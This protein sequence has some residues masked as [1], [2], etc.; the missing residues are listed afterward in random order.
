MAPNRGGGAAP[1]LPH[2]PHPL[3][4]HDPDPP[5]WAVVQAEDVVRRVTESDFGGVLRWRRKPTSPPVLSISDRYIVGTLD[6]RAVDFPCLL[7]FTRCRFERRPDI[8][9]A[10]LCGCQIRNCWLPGLF[11]RNLHSD[12]DVVLTGST[13]T[14]TVDLTDANVNGSLDLAGSTLVNPKGRALHADR[15]VLAGALIGPGITVRGVLRLAGVRTGGNINLAGADLQNETG[16]AFNGNGMHVGG[17]LICGSSD[18]SRDPFRCTGLIFM[19]SARID[20]DFYLRRAKLQPSTYRS[21][22]APFEDPQHDPIAVVVA[23]RIAVDGNVVLDR[24]MT[25]TGTIRMINARIGGSMR[26]TGATVDMSSYA[27][28]NKAPYPYRALHFDGT[29]I[30]GDIDARRARITGESR[31]VDVSVR[32]SVLADD[33]TF[34]NPDGDALEGRRLTVGGNFDCRDVHIAGSFLLPGATIGANLDMRATEITSPGTRRGGGVK[35]S[36]DIRAAQIGRDL[37]CASG[38]S[39]F[40]AHA[41]V[42]MHRATVG[43]EANFDGAVLGCSVSSA[44]LNAFGMSTQDLRLTVGE[45]PCGEVSLRHARCTTLSDNEQFWH[46]TGRIDLED[47]HY[48]ALADPVDLE[49][50]ARVMT[51]LSWLRHAMRG[52]YR[53]GPYDQFATML[54]ASGNEEHASTVMMEKQRWRYHALGEGYRVLGPAVRLWSWLQRWMVGY[55]YRPARALVWLLLLLMLGTLWFGLNL[56]HD[57]CVVGHSPTSAQAGPGAADGPRCSADQDDSGLVWNPFLYTLDLL[58]PIVDFGNKARWH[59]AGADQWIS[60]ILLVMG[61]ILATTA[62]T[63]VTRFLKRQ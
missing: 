40:T 24:D 6:L 10:K 35:S 18:E 23:D 8:Q 59:M 12:S 57:T 9:Q 2:P 46:V 25:S 4:V 36:L 20:S 47:F 63:G 33:A 28:E 1:E 37:I 32:G 43:R 19:P 14:G 51:R 30:R 31:L 58:V 61:W 50:D 49:D 38:R 56:G 42:R 13:V 54:R 52:V 3:D 41:G 39:P 17:N 27:D 60:S 48:D 29:Q 11:G 53:P 26:L 16:L 55:G 15:M 5:P 7:E 45:A 22:A 21:K 44:A 62:A 34:R